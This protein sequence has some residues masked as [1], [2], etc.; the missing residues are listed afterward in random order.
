MRKKTVHM[1]RL[2]YIFFAIWVLCDMI[3]KTRIMEGFHVGLYSYCLRSAAGAGSK[4]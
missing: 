2:F 3:N 4:C 1:N